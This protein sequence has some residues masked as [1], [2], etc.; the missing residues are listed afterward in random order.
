MLKFKCKP[1]KD[2]VADPHAVEEITLIFFN[3]DPK[4]NDIMDYLKDEYKKRS[5]KDDFDEDKFNKLILN[6]TSE[7]VKENL[8]KVNEESLWSNTANRLEFAK[9]V[10]QRLKDIF[11]FEEPEIEVED[12]DLENP[13]D[14]LPIGKERAFEFP[15]GDY[16]YIDFEDGKLFAGTVTNVGITHDYEVEYDFDS[17]LDNNLEKLYTTI[18]E[19]H[20]EYEDEPQTTETVE[21]NKS[22]DTIENVDVKDEDEFDFE[23][24]VKIIVSPHTAW[25]TGAFSYECDIYKDDLYIGNKYVMGVDD[26]EEA[27]NYAYGQ[28]KD[29]LKNLEIGDSKTIKDTLNVVEVAKDEPKENAPKIVKFLY[30]DYAYNFEL[31]RCKHAIEIYDLVNEIAYY[32]D[33][34]DEDATKEIKKYLKANKE[35]SISQITNYLYDLYIGK[36]GDD[37]LK[38]PKETNKELEVKPSTGHSVKSLKA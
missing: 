26:P 15:N 35:A 1:I 24:N 31:N 37:L 19:A 6:V 17:T 14:A 33:L 16:L 5:E 4:V 28:V 36:S 34:Q 12:D 13:L 3:N 32:E 7:F 8:K 30:E 27:A 38:D 29:T 10:Q 20:P 9:K 21:D 2:S 18:I 23:D 25:M 11:E 22:E